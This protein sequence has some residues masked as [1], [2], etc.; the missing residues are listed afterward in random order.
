MALAKIVRVG[1]G[2]QNDFVMTNPG[3]EPSHAEFYVDFS[4]N[5]YL[6]DSGTRSGTFVNG[7]RISSTIILKEGDR[8]SLGGNMFDWA[9]VVKR[10]PTKTERSKQ[11]TTSKKTAVKSA[12]KLS[13]NVQLLL[14]WGAIVL[15][16]LVLSVSV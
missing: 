2:M 6:T 9:N 8:V 15:F 13:E 12:P 11:A 14:I 5:V 10:I 3:V 16:I 1:S 7:Q 4:E